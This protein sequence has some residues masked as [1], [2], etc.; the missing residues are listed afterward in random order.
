MDEKMMYSNSVSV[1]AQFFDVQLT[2]AYQNNE[3]VK[4][5]ET[6]IL[7]PQHFKVLTDVM[8]NTLENYEKSFGTIVI[9]T[10]TGEGTQ[11]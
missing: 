7:S 3:G 4:E 11:D 9:P 2:F 6:I 10:A 8:N 1:N 5:Q